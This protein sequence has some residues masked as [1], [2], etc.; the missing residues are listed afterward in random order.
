MRLPT[1]TRPA[2]ASSGRPGPPL[3]RRRIGRSRLP[4][5]R[6]LLTARSAVAYWAGGPPPCAG[7]GHR[8]G[9]A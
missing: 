7:V 2:S 6:R 5:H 8:R 9:S 3:T 1:F 4:L